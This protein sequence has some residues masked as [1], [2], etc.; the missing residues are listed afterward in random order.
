MAWWQWL[1]LGVGLLGV[2]L[3]VIDAEFYLVFVGV[4][5]VLT[6]LLGLAGIPLPEWAQWLI[7]AGLAVASMVTFR[8][9]VY[10]KIRGRVGHVPDRVQSGDRVFVSTTL[11]PGQSCRVDYRGTTWTARNVGATAIAGGS[12]AVI[13]AINDL[14]LHVIPTA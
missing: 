7:F 2:E 8:K 5:A 1:I 11:E 6:G 14:T 10:H 4:A 12:E 3:F 13:S 9:R